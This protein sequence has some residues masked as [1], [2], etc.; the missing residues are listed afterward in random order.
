MLVAFDTSVLVAGALTLHQFHTRAW[1]WLEAVEQGQL[2]GSI[3]VHALS[4]AYSVFTKIPGGLQPA[5]ALALVR[6]L[7]SVFRVQAMAANNYVAAL[8]RCAVR[9]LRSGA[10]FDA[11]HL[12]DAED[13][14]ADVLLTFNAA[15]FTRMTTA[16]SPKIVVPPDPPSLQIPR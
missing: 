2:Q 15:D 6:R 14:G 16:R 4:E 1:P 11:L 13:A 5:D 9:G 12:I 3:C 8:E 10:V 7:P